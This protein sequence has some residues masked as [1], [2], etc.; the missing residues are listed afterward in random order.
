MSAVVAPDSLPRQTPGQPPGL[1]LEAARRSPRTRWPLYLLAG[2]LTLFVLF[3][4]YL[5]TIAAFSPRTA[6]FAF[7]KSLIPLEISTE[8]LLFFLNSRGVLGSA[9]NSVLVGL[10]TLVLSLA[11][12]TPAGYALARI[13]FPGR[14]VLLFVILAIITRGFRRTPPVMD[15]SEEDPAPLPPAE[16]QQA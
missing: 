14:N 11:I 12:G 2:L 13:E 7:P 3:P 15:F 1:V 16:T 4:I 10:I 8:T 9:G 5:I 6:L